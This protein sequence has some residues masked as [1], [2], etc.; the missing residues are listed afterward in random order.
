[1]GTRGK[2]VWAAIAAG[3]LALL[4]GGVAPA[5]PATDPVRVSAAVGNNM[6]HTPTFV[7][8]EKGIFL[9]HGIDLKL[10]VLMTGMEMSKAMQAG[11]VQLA[12]AA[13]SNFPVAIQQGLE[14]RAV[15]GILG[16][17]TTAF[18]DGTLSV[19]ARGGAGIRGIEDLP[20]KRIAAVT[21]GGGDQYVRLLF[22]RHKL[23]A[24]K[25]VL[26]NIGPGNQMGALQRGDVDAVATWEPYGTLILEKVPGATLVTRNGGL[27]SYAVFMQATTPFLEQS[28]GLVEKYVLG[29]AEA[30]QYT[31][32]HADE[33]AEI[34]TRWVSGLE[35][36]VARKAIRN[37]HFD[38]RLTKYSL[39]AFDESVKVLLEQKKLRAP[40]PASRGMETRFIAKVM[41]ERPDLFTDLKPVP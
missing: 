36:D 38:A 21:G 22:A 5:R 37:L 6:M 23:P 10:R 9:K 8:V 3:V 15:V 30:S 33:A 26:L 41:R 31:R 20:G 17:A 1:M 2:T 39:Q 35:V 16:D 19:T 14:A 25:V 18:W 13:I 12:G 27:L 29:A 7:G 32:Q 40:V 28:T 11:E 4:S 34:T 24:D